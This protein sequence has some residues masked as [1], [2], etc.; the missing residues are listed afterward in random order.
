MAFEQRKKVY[1]EE[2][3]F[4]GGCVHIKYSTDKGDFN[5][6]SSKYEKRT[7]KDKGFRRKTFLMISLKHILGINKSFSLDKRMKFLTYQMENSENFHIKLQQQLLMFDEL[8]CLD[9]H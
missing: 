6:I 7:F 1:E 5:Q 9:F 8:V 4:N 3:N 2:E